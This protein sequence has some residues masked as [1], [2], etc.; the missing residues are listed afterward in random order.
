MKQIVCAAAD[1][2]PGAMLPAR[3]GTMPIVVIR[4]RDGDLHGLFDRCL[5]MGSSLSQGR[6]LTAQTGEGCGDYIEETGRYVVKCPWH[7]YEYDVRTGAT[8]FDTQ[9]RLRTITVR[10]VAGQIVAETPEPDSPAPAD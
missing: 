4:T 10:E 9:V 7:G 5:H 2:A 8:L 1:L 3:V 6:L